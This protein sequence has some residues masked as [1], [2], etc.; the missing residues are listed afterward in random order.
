MW[1][2][3]RQPLLSL[4]VCISS[5]FAFKK[6]VPVKTIHTILKHYKAPHLFPLRMLSGPYYVISLFRS[7]SLT[8][9]HNNS[10]DSFWRVIGKDIIGSRG[11]CASKQC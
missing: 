6:L 5:L 2:L 4:C 7:E 10:I 3:V 8:N 1:G 11:C 9:D